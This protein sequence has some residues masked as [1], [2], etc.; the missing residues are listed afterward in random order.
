MRE[1]HEEL[2]LTDV[3]YTD[4]IPVGRRVGIAATDGI[5]DRHVADVFLYI[6][7]KPLAAYHYQKAELAGLIALEVEQGLHLL[8]GEVATIEVSAVG[9]ETPTV[10]ITASEFIP[11]IDDYFLKVLILTKRCLDGEA[12][13]RV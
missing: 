2:G 8:T 13:L 5:I 9:F 11:T 6:C 1:L 7:D 10:T 4:L 3:H 12:H